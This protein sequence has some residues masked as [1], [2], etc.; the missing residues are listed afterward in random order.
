MFMI[1]YQ[2]LHTQIHIDKTINTHEIHTKNTIYTYNT[3]RY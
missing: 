2:Q 1:K 3:T